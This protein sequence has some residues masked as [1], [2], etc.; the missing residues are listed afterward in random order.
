MNITAGLLETFR[1]WPLFACPGSYLLFS[2]LLTPAAIRL[3]Y[4]PP[5]Q[6]HVY[7]VLQSFGIPLTTLKGIKLPLVLRSL[8][9]P[10]G[11]LFL[12]PPFTWLIFT[13]ASELS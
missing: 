13:H 9:H 11:V 2:T 3:P 10:P 1:I 12:S 7:F 6:V 5:P 8:F 4:A